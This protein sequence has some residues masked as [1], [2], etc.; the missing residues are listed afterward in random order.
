MLRCVAT[1]SEL[2][3]QTESP[4]LVLVFGHRQ[5]ED[6]SIIIEYDLNSL[7][8]E[9]PITGLL[10]IEDFC[11]ATS[12]AKHVSLISTALSSVATSTTCAPTK[13][14]RSRHYI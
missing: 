9:V 8:N 12:Q 6:K 7:T 2:S 10:T 5:D 3:H 4:L 13:R 11:R 14:R 1:L